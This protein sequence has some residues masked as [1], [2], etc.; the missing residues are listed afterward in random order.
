M[1]VA[2]IAITGE[3]NKTARELAISLEESQVYFLSESHALRKTVAE[4]FDRYEGLIFMMALGI[5]IRVIAPLIKSKHTDPAVVVVDE[6]RRFAISALSG[7]EGGANRLANQVASIL[8]AESVITTAS[9][10]MKRLIVGVGCRKGT[11]HEEILKAIDQA[12]EQCESSRED[13]R[14]VA[15]IDLKGGEPGLREACLHLGLPLKIVPID[16]IRNF[17]GPYQRSSF[18]KGKIGVEG[19]SEP[20]ALLAGRRTKLIV[21]K[22]KQGG[23]CVAIAREG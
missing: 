4:I 5:V 16:H 14:C 17:D 7:H 21:P 12:L 11:S 18:V 9:E 1:R 6:N 19:V 23:V 20:C 22:L 3:G 2:I 10:T 13:I 8:R 15:T